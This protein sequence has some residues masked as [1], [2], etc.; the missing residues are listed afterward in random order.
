M[1]KSVAWCVLIAGIVLV[2]VLASYSPAVL[3]D[4][5]GFLKNFV[6]HELLAILGVIL[7]ITIASAGQL[8]LTL[9]EIERNHGTPGSF[10]KTRD[11][12]RSA[13]YWLIALFLIAVLVVVAKP[14]L[15][16]TPWAETLFNGGAIVILLWNGLILI[17]IMQAIFAIKA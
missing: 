3:G 14:L 12:I 8:H 7:A 16:S 13:A 6:N 5:N 1:T 15:A 2:C 4:S 11:G 10:D 17:S 9:N